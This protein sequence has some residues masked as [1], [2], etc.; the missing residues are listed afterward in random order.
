MLST[1]AYGSVAI[2]AYATIQ[3]NFDT[4][5]IS[6]LVIL[7]TLVLSPLVWYIRLLRHDRDKYWALKED[8]YT[9][10]VL[11]NLIDASPGIRDKM[12]KKFF[13]YNGKY[14]NAQLIAN[15]GQPHTNISN[16]ILLDKIEQSFKTLF[17]K[18]NTKKD[19]KYK[20][21]ETKL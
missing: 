15:W 21:S 8:A 10:G 18:I 7:I 11:A 19:K 20:P 14:N 1:P 6:S 5:K 3:P 9:K 16:N 12:L 17:D 13:D 4:F 2:Y